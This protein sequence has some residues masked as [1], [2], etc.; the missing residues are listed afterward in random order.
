MEQ[1]TISR[2]QFRLN[3]ELTKRKLREYLPA[4]LVTNL[5]TLLL[6]SVDGLIVGNF[7]GKD[8]LSSVSIFYPATVFIGVISV[9]LSS[10][11]AAR[12]SVG[13]GKIDIEGLLKTRSALKLLMILGAIVVA[14]IQIPIVAAIIASYHLSPEMNK[15]VWNYAIGV[16]I[17]MPFGLIS[18]IGVLQLQISG[19]MKVLMGMAVMEGA[20]NLL[21]D[22]FFVAV[23]KMGVAGAGYGTAGANILRAT[24]TVIYLLKKTETFY[25]GKAKPEKSEI[26]AILFHGLP[27]GSSSFMMAVQ[28]YAMMAII[29]AAFGDSG[30]VIKGVCT[31][32]ASI[33]FVLADSVQG[34]ARPLIGLLSG[35][36]ALKFLRVL[37]RQGIILVTVLSG[38]LVAV[39][40][41][42]PNIFYTIHGVKVIPDGGLLSL[43]FFVVYFLFRGTNSLF[44]LYFTNRKILRFSTILTVVGN[45]TLPLFAFLLSRIF[46]PA[47]IW[48][49]YTLTE[50]V[51]L[52]ANVIRYTKLLQKEKAMRNRD[53]TDLY[54]TVTPAEA[55]E[56]SRM[57]RRYADEKGINKKHA[58]RVA[59]CMEEM[60]AY[61]EKTHGRGDV[62]VQ[63]IIRFF[64]DSAML[65][66][67]DD[68]QC[69]FL[70]K[71]EEKQKIITS[72]YGLLKKL[73]KEVEY[74]YL[75]NLNYTVCKY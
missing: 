48:W 40:E 53:E 70:D 31:F 39:A 7:V 4:M 22:L 72:N 38:A 56:T 8:A 65:M 33:S 46:P 68:G 6:V 57:I 73:S 69:I 16:M 17:S 62:S 50:V 10:G 15:L 63:I 3:G 67:V 21:L 32:V 60:V 24:V 13:M 43:R 75:L 58:F 52:I 61:A 23:L 2:E 19:K 35:A 12:L 47:W 44:R 66:I 14:L 5:S 11:A 74:Q 9:I 37:M 34:S 45:A 59:L 49:S 55:I 29:L 64:P 51:L 18:T 36:N 20:A 25:S 27:E 42:F 28:N 54:L 41:V 26:K 30:G 1:T 71:E